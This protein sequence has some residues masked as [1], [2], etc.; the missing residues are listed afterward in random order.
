MYTFQIK[1]IKLRVFRK[2]LDVTSGMKLTF[3][4][5]NRPKPAKLSILLCLT[6]DDFTRQWGTPESQW[7]NERCR[8]QFVFPKGYVKNVFKAT[9]VTQNWFNALFPPALSSAFRG[10]KSA[11]SPFQHGN[12]CT[13]TALTRFWPTMR[14]TKNV[15]I[16]KSD[17]NYDFFCWRS[18]FKNLC[19]MLL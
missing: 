16:E 8:F 15:W 17:W 19:I 4:R 10:P 5:P 14:F 12:K 2:P 18:N 9:E 7:V 6:P 11:H 13:L 3:W 1:L